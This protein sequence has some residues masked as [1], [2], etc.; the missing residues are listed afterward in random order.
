MATLLSPADADTLPAH[1]CS[2][3]SLQEREPLRIPGYRTAAL[4]ATAHDHAR[5]WLALRTAPGGGHPAAP[6]PELAAV[7]T[8]LPPS[9]LNFPASKYLADAA[10]LPK[11]ADCGRQQLEAHLHPH[12]LA[13]WDAA[14]GGACSQ[15]EDGAVVDQL[16]IDNRTGFHGVSRVT[17]SMRLSAAINGVCVH[18]AASGHCGHA[19]L[20]L[21]GRL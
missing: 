17:G 3:S 21:R 18:L 9:E 14:T 8:A 16:R 5:L 13:L 20:Q 2:P 12:A 1:A 11:L 6:L 19:V 7:V 15:G 4:A 10:V